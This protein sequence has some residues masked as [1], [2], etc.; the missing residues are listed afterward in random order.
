MARLLILTLSA[1]LAACQGYYQRHI[2]ANENSPYF[3]VP[4]D[5]TFE[6]MQPVTIPAKT[7]RVFFQGGK[8]MTIHNVNEYLPYCEL[9]VSIARGAPQTVNPDEFIVFKVYQSLRFQ[10]GQAPLRLAATR[11]QDGVEAFQL[12][13]TVMELYS[14]RQPDVSRLV[15]AAWGLPQN[16]SFVSIGLIRELLADYFS[17]NLNLGDKPPSAVRIPAERTRGNVFG[18]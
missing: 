11:D 5:S 4:I 2:Y 17:L 14:S 18:Y 8:L 16:M 7:R 13:A 3:Y 10:V 15:C 6:L 12:V 1:V 9:Q